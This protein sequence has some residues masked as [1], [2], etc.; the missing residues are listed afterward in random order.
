MASF[1]FVLAQCLIL[2]CSVVFAHWI[3][4]KG[5]QLLCSFS[6]HLASKKF[7]Y[8]FCAVLFCL[9]II[10]VSSEKLPIDRFLFYWFLKEAW[11]LYTALY[12]II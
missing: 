1:Y 7:K 10:K 3:S 2:V 12:I 4:T 6:K 8:P 9:Y 5:N 11:L